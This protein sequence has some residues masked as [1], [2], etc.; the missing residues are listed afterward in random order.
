ME[1]ILES[2][3]FPKEKWIR[4]ASFLFE[5]DTEQWWRATQHLKFLDSDLLM[6]SWEDFRD[7]FYD[8]YLPDHEKDRLDK[9]FKNLQQGSMSVAKYE[10]TFSRLE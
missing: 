9:K 3:E 4:L 6:I 7:V 1:K 2:M 5:G 10:A 8:K